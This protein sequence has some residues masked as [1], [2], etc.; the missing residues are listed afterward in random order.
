M[1]IKTLN[2]TKTIKFNFLVV[3]N[4]F[5]IFFVDFDGYYNV[6]TDE[7]RPRPKYISNKC[8]TNIYFFTLQRFGPSPSPNFNIVLR[9]SKQ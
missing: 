9:T 6:R 8:G 7:G 1:E 2:L 5:L 3:F 4:N